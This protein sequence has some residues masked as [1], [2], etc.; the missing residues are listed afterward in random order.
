MKKIKYINGLLIIALALVLSTTS[1]ADDWS[2]AERSFGDFKADFDALKKLNVTEVKDLV[3]AICT[4]AED[5]RKSVASSAA[6][7]VKS[8]VN[9]EYSDLEKKKND[10]LAKLAKVLG[11]S[12]FSS[13]YSKANEYKKDVDSKWVSIVKMTT[14][15]R[16][17]NHPVIAFMLDTGQRA[18]ADYQNSSSKCGVK[19]FTLGSA[20]RADCINP[21]GCIAIELKPDNSRANSLGRTQAKRYADEINL[22]ASKWLPELTKKNSSFKGC[23]GKKFSQRVDCYKLCPDIDD[24]GNFKSVSANWRSGC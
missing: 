7:R 24:E 22:N 16:G 14:S 8:K 21:T 13:K 17:A 6:A 5:D 11:N 2:D 23:T 12:S 9:G 10:A 3:E 4:A 18:H 15:T 19:E 1:Q 20:G